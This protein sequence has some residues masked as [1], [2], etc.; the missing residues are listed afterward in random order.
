MCVCV[1]LDKWIET[2]DYRRA[3]SPRPVDI[4]VGRAKPRPHD[5]EE[6]NMCFGP[7]TFFKKY[8]H[9]EQKD[10]F[11][12]FIGPLQ[13]HSRDKDRIF[14]DTSHANNDLCKES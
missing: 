4:A 7:F 13:W 9:T 8:T 1:Q 11:S 14:I 10:M 6:F 3:R 5:A 12:T 2:R